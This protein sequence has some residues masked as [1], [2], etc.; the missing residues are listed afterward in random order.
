MGTI[1]T[2]KLYQEELQN[3]G[4]PPCNMCGYKGKTYK[5]YVFHLAGW[6]CEEC[7]E[8]LVEA[9]CKTAFKYLKYKKGCIG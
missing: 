3:K 7:K 8:R 5:T 9:I 6:L 1:K 4:I 2:I